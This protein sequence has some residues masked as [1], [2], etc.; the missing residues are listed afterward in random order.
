MRCS[1][2]GWEGPMPGLFRGISVTLWRDAPSH[3]VYFYVY[4]RTKDIIDSWERNEG[5]AAGGS[6]F[7]MFVAG[8][9]AGA[10]SWL[11]VYPLDVCKSRMQAEDRCRSPYRTWLDCAAQTYQQERA[12][13]FWRGLTPTLF[14]GFLVNAA[15]FTSYESCIGILG[16]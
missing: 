12:G 3:G 5:S 6:S 10:A 4:H 2:T 9:L 16:A 13:A 15:I 1:L 8:G 7:G 11:S 14:R